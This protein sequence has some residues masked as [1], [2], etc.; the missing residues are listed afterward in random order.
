MTIF[1][2]VPERALLFPILPASDNVVTMWAVRKIKE[3]IAL[4][5]AEAQ[6]WDV[7]FEAEKDGHIHLKWNMEKAQEIRYEFMGIQIQI[8]RS[9]LLMLSKK[10]KVTEDHLP[11]FDKFGIRQVEE[12]NA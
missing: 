10:G 12:K 7:R 6:E 8:I 9:S 1:L 11:L 2:S 5:M 4:T 3:D